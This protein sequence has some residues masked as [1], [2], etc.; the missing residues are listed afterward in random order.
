[1]SDQDAIIILERLER[2]EQMLLA[3]TAEPEPVVP[4]KAACLRGVEAEAA[5]A[6]IQGQSLR[7]YLLERAANHKIKK[8]PREVRA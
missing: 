4:V 5:M 1:M 3:L 8:Q 6:V 7:E 2:I